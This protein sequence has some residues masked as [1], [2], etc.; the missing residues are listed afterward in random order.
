MRIACKFVVCGLRISAG[1]TAYVVYPPEGP[2]PPT[3]RE[4]IEEAEQEVR[5]LR[6]RRAS[7]APN[8]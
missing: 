8:G 1:Q 7:D 2:R 4:G 5:Q 3:S 6:A